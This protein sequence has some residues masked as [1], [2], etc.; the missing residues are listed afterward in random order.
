MPIRNVVLPDGKKIAEFRGW[1]KWTQE[2]LAEQADISVRTLAELEQGKRTV[3]IGTLAPVARALGVQLE[4]IVNGTS[5][6]RSRGDTA[7][8][9]K[10]LNDFFGDGAGV[11]AE[12]AAIIIQSDSIEDLVK[13]LV[14]DLPA[15][16]RANPGHRLYKAR[17][18]INR[19]DADGASA[20][21]EAFQDA[22]FAA[23]RFLLTDHSSEIEDRLDAGAP[24]TISMG[25][26][27]TDQT[28]S[29][30]E[31]VCGDWMHISKGPEGDAIAF[32][33]KLI[34]KLGIST[35][36]ISRFKI[37]DSSEDAAFSCFR[38]SDWDQE[39]S[40]GESYLE[41]WLRMTPARKT[42]RETARD[43]AIVFRHTTKLKNPERRQVHFVLA[44]FT[45]RGTA[46]AG[47]YLAERWSELHAKH[48]VGK[49]DT[50]TR[51]DFLLMI[52]GP[53]WPSRFQEWGVD[54]SF[55]AITPDRVRSCGFEWNDT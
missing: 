19:W 27:F 24:F 18:W 22:G 41:R 47:R 8:L 35:D 28:T 44:G 21:R 25:L 4:Q 38:P 14:E 6:T 12:E 37:S 39:Y 9:K 23:P 34:E 17:T 55:E 30:I 40:P 31:T 53:S 33:K 11:R 48:V 52:E 5:Q 50:K 46:I 2:K 3:R 1:K 7:T 13:G 36:K 49:T 45:E 32:N 15:K 51:G 43:Y 54:P 10:P 29:R 26:G 20:I 16:L 42:K